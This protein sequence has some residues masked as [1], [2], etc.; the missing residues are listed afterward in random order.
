MSGRNAKG[1]AGKSVADGVA[2]GILGSQAALSFSVEGQLFCGS[3][4]AAVGLKE[5]FEPLAC[6]CEQ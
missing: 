4:V 2:A 6:A 3:L 5:R 1:S